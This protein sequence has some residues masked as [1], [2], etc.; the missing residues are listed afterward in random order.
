[1]NGFCSNDMIANEYFLWTAARS[2]AAFVV[3]ELLKG[4]QTKRQQ[5]VPQS[6]GFSDRL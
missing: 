4:E 6:K 2:A 1:M 5:S 3:G